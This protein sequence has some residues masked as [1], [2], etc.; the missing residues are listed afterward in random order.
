MSR[1][2]ERS[3]ALDYAARCAAELGKPL[4]VY[5]GLRLRYPWA[6]ERLHAFILQGMADNRARAAALGIN[7]WPYVEGEETL[8]RKL[9]AE[10]AR[11]AVLVVSDDYP[12]FTV[13]GQSAGLVR[14]TD[15]AVFAVDGNSIVPL[16]LLGAP[17]SAAAHLRPRIHKLFAAAWAHRAEAVPALTDVAT[18]RRHSAVRPVGRRRVRNFAAAAVREP[19]ASCRCDAGRQPGG[20]RTPW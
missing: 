15:A 11:R 7:Y 3:H 2:L 20:A 14:A 19:R 16:S 10:L 1:R 8:D 6:S 9:V 5:E 18:T 13:P 17:A 12:A 4:V